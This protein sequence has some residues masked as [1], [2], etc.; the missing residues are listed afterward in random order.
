MCIGSNIQY[1]RQAKSMTQQEMAEALSV[2]R[3]TVSKW[4]MD[5]VYPE[6]PKL[7]KLC[8]LFH[9]SMD[10]L[11]NEDLQKSQGAYSEIVIKEVAG[12]RMAR[13]VMITP[14]PENDVN[15]YMDRWALDSG[16]LDVSDFKPKRIGWDF[17][18]VSMEQQNRFGLRGY[19][20]A[21][22]LPDGFEP[23]CP[24]AEIAGQE[25]AKYACITI[26]DPF[27][28]AFELIPGAYKKILEYLGMNG[29]KENSNSTA[30]A[31]FEYVYEEN[32]VC[33]MD[34]HIHVDST[35]SANV[36]TNFS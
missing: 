12:F 8:E 6:I 36:H 10:A 11:L 30:L 2:S 26:R 4:E 35:A 15:A 19:V 27:S 23:K 14:C 22:I 29:F 13:Y 20:A 18:F 5:Q 32:G 21:Y 7:K 9:C 28:R 33:F 1:L 17:P 16:L 24:G 25:T 31:C 34:V 3:Q